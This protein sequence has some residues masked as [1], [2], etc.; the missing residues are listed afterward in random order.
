ML[1]QHCGCASDRRPLPGQ[2]DGWQIAERYREQ[3]PNLPVVYA[4]GFSP[5]P[6]RPVPGSRIVRKPFLQDEIVRLVKDLGEAK[7]PPPV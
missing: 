4:T 5:V 7:G 2:V 3:Y 1:T 6:P